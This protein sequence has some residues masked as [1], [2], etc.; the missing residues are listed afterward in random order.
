[1]IAHSSEIDHP[2]H[3]IHASLA[4]DEIPGTGAAVRI[5]PM[6]R[7]R[8]RSAVGEETFGLRRDV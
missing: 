3:E 6:A 2:R 8:S 1:V 4:D 5:S 7:R